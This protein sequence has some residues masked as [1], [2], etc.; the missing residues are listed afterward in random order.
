MIGNGKAYYYDIFE[1]YSAFQSSQGL[2]VVC[3]CQWIQFR[4]DKVVSLLPFMQKASA[5][6]STFFIQ[7]VVIAQLHLHK[8]S[9]KPCDLGNANRKILLK[10]ITY[11]LGII[12]VIQFRDYFCAWIRSA[13]I[14]TKTFAA[15]Y[16][17]KYLPHILNI[18]TIVAVR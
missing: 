8:N 10:G 12:F 5:S 13:Q 11:V 16:Q 7:I 4:V 1:V 18:L 17:R 6:S 14:S 15:K 2:A 9:A 3:V